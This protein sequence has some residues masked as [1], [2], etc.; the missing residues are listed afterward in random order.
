MITAFGRVFRV[1][2]HLL[3]RAAAG[4]A[5]CDLAQAS[6][7]AHQRGA[8]GGREDVDFVCGA[9]RVAHLVSGFQLPQQLL[10]GQR[11]DDGFY[12]VHVMLSLSR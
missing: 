7:L 3:A 8:F 1:D 5:E 10:A 11:V 9:F 4:C 12:F 6:H 2:V